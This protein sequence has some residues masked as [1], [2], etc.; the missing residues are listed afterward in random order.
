M[1]LYFSAQ[2]VPGGEVKASKPGTREW[3]W[4]Y[5]EAAAQL[6]EPGSVSI[7][8]LSPGIIASTLKDYPYTGRR[9]HD[10]RGPGGK[11]SLRSYRAGR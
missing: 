11:R 6:V 7:E 8:D 4:T 10:R 2:G 9:L 5:G 1:P 3:H